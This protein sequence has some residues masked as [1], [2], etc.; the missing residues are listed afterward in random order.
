MDECMDELVSA[1][2]DR[3]TGCLIGVCR[4]WW[5]Q[6]WMDVRWKGKRR[7]GEMIEWLVERIHEI[8]W[9][10][11]YIYIYININK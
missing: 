6:D 5:V 1:W 9:R 8:L 7:S 11:M 2:V 4:D 3:W 10:Y